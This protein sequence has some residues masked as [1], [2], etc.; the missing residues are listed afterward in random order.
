MVSVVG[1]TLR[2][3]GVSDRIVFLFAPEFGFGRNQDSMH[4][5]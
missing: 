3:D 1:D 4:L 2:L 5:V